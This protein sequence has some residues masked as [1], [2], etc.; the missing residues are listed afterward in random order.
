MNKIVLGLL[1]FILTACS[2]TN[3]EINKTTPKKELSQLMYLDEA[4]NF[5]MLVTDDEPGLINKCQLK[6]NE[7]MSLLQPLHAMIDEELAKNMDTLDEST[8][9]K[10]DENCH[11][12][13]F[14]DLTTNN[15]RK[16]KLLQEA[17]NTSKKKLV[18][19][20]NKSAKWLCDSNL[21]KKLKAEV[22]PNPE[23]L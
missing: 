12:G 6:A 4:A 11:C 7:A 15:S 20:A 5:L 9:E 8:L 1:L 17:Q 3:T 2:T 21:L 19:C 14:S 18:E 23:G 10:C 13:L 22:E 16:Q